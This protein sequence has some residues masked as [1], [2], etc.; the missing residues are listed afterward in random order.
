MSKRRSRVL[1]RT[2]RMVAEKRDA[3]VAASKGDA[4]RKSVKIEDCPTYSHSSGSSVNEMVNQSGG[5]SEDSTSPRAAGCRTRRRTMSGG[6]AEHHLLTTKTGKKIYT[7]GR[8]PWY[9]KKGKSLKHPFVIGVCGG[10]ASGKTT[11]AEKIVERLGIPWVTILSMDSFY[12]VLTPEEIKAAHES[13][14][15]FDGPN[16]FDFDLLYEVLK[17]LR[18]G[19]SV[20]VP[21]YDFNTHS[22]D[23]NSKMMYGADVLIFEGILAFHD[24][25]IKNLMD[26]KVFVDTDGDLRLARRI[27]RDVTDRGRDI[28]GIMEQYFTF[29]KP[30]FDKYIAPCMDSADLIVPRGGEN[31]VAIDMIVQ[32]VMAQLV[33]RGYDRN[34]NNRD[35]HDLVRDDLPDCLPENLFILKETP[36]VKGLVTFVRDRETS[37]DNHIFYSDRL[38]RILIEECMNHMPY[39]DVEIEM[40][41]GRKTIGKRKDAQ[42]CGLPIMRAGECMETALRSIVKDCVI[43]KILIQTNETTFDPELHYIRL[44]PHITR[45]KVIIMD[46][47]VTT[48]SAAMMAIRVLLDHDVKEEDIFVA[49]LLMGQQGAHALA[50]AFP[51]VKL[52]TTAMDHQMTENCYLIPGMGNFGDRYYGTGLEQDMDEPFDM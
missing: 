15:N 45:Y 2:T 11:V 27:V 8:P 6:R 26:M 14:Y 13:R 3:N 28:D 37:R 35:R 42:I 43:G 51:K 22:R 29:V 1:Q 38:M 7:K 30:A 33:E 19:K 50:Y 49:S 17:R 32:N 10:S 24:E 12:K 48:G 25:R 31:D 41:G 4:N 44:P 20:D 23:P 18:E 34:Q 47:T 16:A 21:V 39:K 40:A 9:D 52:I 46:A 5:D 36:Q